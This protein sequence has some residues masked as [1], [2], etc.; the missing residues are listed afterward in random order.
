MKLILVR[1]HIL[2]VSQYVCNTPNG[3]YR[4][5]SISDPSL[6]DRVRRI[7]EDEEGLGVAAAIVRS[8]AGPGR[9]VELVPVPAHLIQKAKAGCDHILGLA[10]MLNDG[11][12]DS[13][14]RRWIHA[15]DQDQPDAG[16]WLSL[17][18]HCPKCG[19]A[20]RPV[21]GVEFKD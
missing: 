11:E 18:R 9:R 8:Y 5:L 10:Y 2:G 19:V 6:M 15:L 17:F 14:L 12:G 1:N 3:P 13:W 16:D 7:T 20:L 21:E 4:L